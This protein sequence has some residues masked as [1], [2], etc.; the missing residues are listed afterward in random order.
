MELMRGGSVA[1]LLGDYGPLP[2]DVAGEL[3]AQLAQ[4]SRRYMRPAYLISTRGRSGILTGR[5]ALQPVPM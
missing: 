5:S 1:D 3:L 4:G 2:V